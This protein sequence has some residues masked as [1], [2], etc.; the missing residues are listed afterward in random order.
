M[1]T[2]VHRRTL[3][4]LLAATA[5][6]PLAA[7]PVRAA[8]P[9]DVRLV[10]LADLH[11]AYERLP[12][13]LA[14]VDAVRHDAAGGPVLTIINGDVFESGNA[15]A[16]RSKGEADWAFLERLVAGG[17]VVL[18][19]GNHE[20]D[21]TD[22]L[23]DVV[24]RA[25]KL[26][27][28]VLSNIVDT[29]TGKPYAPHALKIAVGGRKVALAALA[30]NA[31]NT[32]PKAIRPTLTIPDPVVWAKDNLPGLMKD[33]DI[34]VILSHAGVGPD[35]GILPL[36]PD[37]TLLVGGH[38]HLTFRHDQGGTRYI[39]TGSWSRGFAVASITGRAITLEQIDVAL[40]G[41]RDAALAARID[42][43][44]A[45]HMT[46][47]ERAVVGQSPKALGLDDT[48]RLVASFMARA[49]GGDVGL[50]GH[51]TLGTGLPAGAVT[52]FAFDAV[53]RFEGKLMKAEVSAED[54][55]K[56]Y[57]V[58]N[59]DRDMPLADRMGD[60]VYANPVEIVAG[61]RYT[62]ITNDWTA[63]NRKA[64]LGREDI[65]FQPI[66]NALL[67]PTVIAALKG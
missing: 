46:E 25:E 32:Y 11:S 66:D 62:L 5:L 15:V 43:V 13:L 53:V 54:L 6:M 47:A 49:H 58:S 3:L 16:S 21:L 33:R 29:R 35:K 67:K 24:A 50:V 37:G 52:K 56:I 45:R 19:I 17:P 42:D 59:Q 40:D 55:A 10:L 20:P 26:G 2:L 63:L 14:A 39:H 38:D 34:N 8:A 30:T 27:V 57:A 48:G 18:N 31:I 12:Q 64:Y 28:H 51:T 22:D 44:L 36:L 1:P 7:R 65:I 4:G 23:A 9:A 61:K 41:P 60:Y